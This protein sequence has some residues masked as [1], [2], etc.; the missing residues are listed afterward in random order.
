MV[1][2]TML[3]GSEPLATTAAVDEEFAFTISTTEVKCTGST[4][5]G[6]APQIEAPNKGSAR[7]LEATGCKTSATS[8][9]TLTGGNA[10]GVIGILPVTSEVTLEGT[11]A[12]VGTI[13]PQ[14][15]IFNTIAFTGGGCALSGKQSVTGKVIAEGPTSQGERTLQSA[16][17]VTTAASGDLKIGSTSAS[18]SGS[19]LFQL[20]SSK[21]WSYL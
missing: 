3:S 4:F 2:G 5:N 19:V 20:A 8:P 9:C 1:N 16:S 6:V 18:L 15:A 21:V 13:K 17:A 10:G 12:V 14:G 7:G 11:A